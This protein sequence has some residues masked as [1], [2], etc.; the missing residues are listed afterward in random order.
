MTSS[1]SQNLPPPPPPPPSIGKTAPKPPIVVSEGPAGA[2][3]VELLIFNGW[4]FKD[5]WAYWVRSHS[6][7]DIGVQLHATGDVRNGFVF[8]IKRNYDFHDDNSERPSTRIPLQWI[9]GKFFDERAMMNNGVF[10]LDDVPVC[11]FEASV[12]KVKAPE[13]SLNTVTGTTI[14]EGQ[15]GQK[16]NQSNCQTWV[17]ES[18]DQLVR[19]EIFNQE[20]AAYLHAIEQ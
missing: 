2:Y 18:A 8:Q 14:A 19:D 9:D 16:V 1:D 11:G 3:L 17:V 4:P 20:V 13:K 6:D 15:K 10:T 7:P 5:H 12:Y